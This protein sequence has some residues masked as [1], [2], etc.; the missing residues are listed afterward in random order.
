MTPQSSA[1]HRAVR[2]VALL[3]L[4]VALGSAVGGTARALVSLAAIELAGAGF[5][6][7]T[8]VANALGSFAIGFYAAL[9]G[10]DGR[11]LVGTRQRQLVM[12]GIC[13]GFTTF[14]VFSLETLRFLVAGEHGL[15][16]LNVAV[17]IVIWL[18][19]VWLGDAL[20]ARLNR[21]ASGR[22]PKGP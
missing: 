16:A 8:L 10:P 4:F 22:R 3:Y 6:W 14:S 1:R 13:G 7:G 21:L 20:A 9:T 17:S 19:A 15:A 11:L 12:A 18:V 2:E 5:P